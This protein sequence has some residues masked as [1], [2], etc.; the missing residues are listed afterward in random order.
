MLGALHSRLPELHTELGIETEGR[1]LPGPSVRGAPSPRC[2]QLG[3]AH[4]VTCFDPAAPQLPDRVLGEARAQPGPEHAHV[5]GGAGLRA[6]RPSA[7]LS[8]HAQPSPFP[9]EG[10]AAARRRRPPP[11]LCAPTPP[12]DPSRA[13]AF[14]EPGTGLQ[15]HLLAARLLGGWGGAPPRPAPAPFGRA[16]PAHC[17]R[18]PRPAPA[19]ASS[20]TRPPARARRPAA[21]VPAPASVLNAGRRSQPDGPFLCSGT[22]LL[23]TRTEKRNQRH[24]V[25]TDWMAG[26]KKQQS[27]ER[28]S[29][30][31]FL[32]EKTRYFLDE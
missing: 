9:E 5:P 8:P 24:R 15:R 21:R 4:A 19:P 18:P 7:G 10:R 25:I 3:G 16:P 1:P 29:A 22:Y 31:L 12:V 30:S 2:A 13:S 23:V 27:A 6:A 20:S 28:A 26:A 17:S 14:Q 11:G 32:K